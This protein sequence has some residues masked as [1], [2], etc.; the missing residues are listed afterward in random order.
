M[1]P[2]FVRVFASF[3]WGE[4]VGGG[5]GCRVYRFL[6]GVV[7]GL[8]HFWGRGVGWGP[9]IDLGCKKILG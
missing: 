7:F 8:V 9:G 4:R 1:Q 3:H 2:R 6:F 5:A